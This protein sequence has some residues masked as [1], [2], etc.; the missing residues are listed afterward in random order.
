MFEQEAFDALVAHEKDE[1]EVIA[2]YEAFASQTE[3]D[4]VRFL[5]TLIVEDERRHHKVLEQLA[6]TIRAQSTFQETGPRLPYF[7][8]HRR[9]DQGLLGAT[10]RFLDVERNDRARLKVLA[11]TVGA[12]G[13]EV[14]AFVVDLLR[15]DT[16]RHIRILKFIEHLVRRSPIR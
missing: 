10:R 15:T 3:S 8:V 16:E 1:E 14:D 11:K 4:L 13:G 2:A 7:D 6:N 9:R 5:V 12:C